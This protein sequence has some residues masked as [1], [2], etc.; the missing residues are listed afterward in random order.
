MSRVVGIWQD[1]AKGGLELGPEVF[2]GIENLWSKVNI[3]API[4]P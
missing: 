2:D 4:S 1:A 3:P